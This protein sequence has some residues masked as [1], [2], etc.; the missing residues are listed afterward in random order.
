MKN[1]INLQNKPMIMA[2]IPFIIFVIILT[3]IGVWYF[4]NKSTV[5]PYK[6]EYINLDYIEYVEEV[7]LTYGNNSAN[8]KKVLNKEDTKEIIKIISSAE[9]ARI[10]ALQKYP[11]NKIN[12]VIIK[13]YNGRICYAFRSNGEVEVYDPDHPLKNTFYRVDNKTTQNIIKFFMKHK[14]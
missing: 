8:N 2:I 4:A 7:T 9:E 11:G 5:I 12:R 1:N 3:I 10:K 6:N 13:N 14:S